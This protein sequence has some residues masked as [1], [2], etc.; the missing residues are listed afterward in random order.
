MRAVPLL[1]QHTKQNTRKKNEP[2]QQSVPQPERRRQHHE[3]DCQKTQ[4]T[5]TKRSKQNAQNKTLLEMAIVLL[6][7]V[8]QPIAT[9]S[10]SCRLSITEAVQQ[11]RIVVTYVVVVTCWVEIPRLCETPL[12]FL[13]ALSVFVPSL[14]WQ[15]VQFLSGSIS[16][17]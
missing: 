14:S 13:S 4:S 6:R 3:P 16:L 12:S 2:K 9:G 1:T 7:P 8:A 15:I 17:S 11:R 5:Q 10:S